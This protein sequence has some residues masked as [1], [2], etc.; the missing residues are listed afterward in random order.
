MPQRICSEEDCP[1]SAV[2]LGMC[3][4]HYQRRRRATAPQCGVD[5]CPQRVH[6][7]GVCRRHYDKVLSAGRECRIDGCL[8]V[9]RAVGLCSMHYYR[10]NKHGDPGEAELRRKPARPC[11]VEG[12]ANGAVT[13]RDLCPT[14]ARRKRLYGTETGAF[15]THRK[16][17]VCGNPAMH[18]PRSSEHCESHYIQFVF[19]LYLAGTIQASKSD[20]GYVFL[21]VRKKRYPVHRLVMERELGR[22]LYPFENVHHKNGRRA[23]HDISNLELWVKPQPSGQRPEDLVAWVVQHYPD[24]VVA[25]QRARKQEQR[26]GQLR[27]TD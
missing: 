20:D 2:R 7:A 19:D 5:D 6:A 11:K 14:H 12:C 22:P 18:G 26:T 23:D 4:A 3:S 10:L 21:T 13:S 9:P 15:T 1:D 25:E 24:L 8:G 16:C 27:F 17:V